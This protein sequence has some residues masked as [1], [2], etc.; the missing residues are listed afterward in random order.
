METELLYD[1]LHRS[2][3]DF[4]LHGAGKTEKEWMIDAI[5]RQ[6]DAEI[7]KEKATQIADQ[8]YAGL[9]AFRTR[10]ATKN[11]RESLETAGVPVADIQFL[12]SGIQ[13]VSEGLV[14]DFSA[15]KEEAGAET[16][17][18]GI[19]QGISQ[20]V[21]QKKDEVASIAALGAYAAAKQGAFGRTAANLIDEHTA[22]AMGGAF[23][24]TAETATNFFAGKIEKEEATENLKNAGWALVGVAVHQGLKV[25]LAVA[26][27]AAKAYFPTFSAWIETGAKV[28][29]KTILPA[30]AIAVTAGIK[31]IAGGIKDA[32]NWLKS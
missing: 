15:K 23:A 2:K 26:K 8:M 27:T 29:E 13:S 1:L 25:G 30:V 3:K 4:D 5:P 28:A 19:Q 7:T 6:I 16:L 17:N 24:Q 22:G 14:R 21:S 9:D 10:Y 32:W 31:N 11:G 12:E 20:F 18:S